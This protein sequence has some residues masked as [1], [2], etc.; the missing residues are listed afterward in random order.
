MRIL[1]PAVLSLLLT[2]AAAVAFAAPQNKQEVPSTAKARVQ[3]GAKN[4]VAD[5]VGAYNTTP[6]TKKES[7]VVSKAD[8]AKE[9]GGKNVA[10]GGASAK[11]SA[12][13]FGR[14]PSRGNNNVKGGTPVKASTSNRRYTGAPAKP[15]GGGMQAAPRGQ[16]SSMKTNTASAGYN[17][18]QDKKADS[19]DA[20]AKKA[21]DGMAA[22]LGKLKGLTD[23]KMK[24]EG[25]PVEKK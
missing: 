13:V 23:E 17:H 19:V 9:Q 21:S 15:S 2:A 20:G 14:T 5:N 8:I 3:A 18:S 24:K 16:T 12:N 7:F 11:G 4:T 1:L 10:A 25:K 6:K 22:L